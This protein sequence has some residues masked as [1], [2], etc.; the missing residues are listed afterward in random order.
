MPGGP[1]TTTRRRDFTFPLNPRGDILRVRFACEGKEVLEFVVQ[2]EAM[3]DGELRPVVRYDGSHGHPHRD[4][5]DW[6]GTTINKRWAPVG[7][8]NADALTAAIDDLQSNWPR[9][10]EAFLRRRP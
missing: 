8:M 3:I 9:Y 10:L 5:L 2:Y 1:V 4:T 7:T 6:D